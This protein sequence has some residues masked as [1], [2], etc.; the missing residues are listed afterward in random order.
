MNKLKILVASALDDSIKLL[1]NV[2]TSN[3]KVETVGQIR[4]LKRLENA[5]YKYKPDVLFFDIAMPCFKEIE[6]I[7]NIRRFNHE[8][9][10]VLV[11]THFDYLD[12]LINLQ[13]FYCLNKPIN[14]SELNDLI[15]SL[16]SHNTFETAANAKIKL[17]IKNGFVYLEIDEILMLEAEG[18]YTRIITTSNEEY[19]SS[20]NMGRL[21]R[22]LDPNYFFRVNRGCILNSSYLK[23]IDKKQFIGTVM[24]NGTQIEL[25]VSRSFISQFNKTLV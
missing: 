23:V 13:I 14:K 21:Y 24:I 6:L 16:Y 19:V 2:L 11:S 4:D 7:R 1:H 3:Q 17:P 20:Y 25:P 12:K 10:I 5:I 8:L 18:N 9:S 15:E 22:K